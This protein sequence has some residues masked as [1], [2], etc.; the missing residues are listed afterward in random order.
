MDDVFEVQDEIVR[1]VMVAL[2]GKLETASLERA[3][4]KPT[5]KP[6]FLRVLA[7]RS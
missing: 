5:E 1:K 6:E 3:K 2:V 7:A 4:R